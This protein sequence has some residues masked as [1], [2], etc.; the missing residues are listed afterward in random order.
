MIGKTIDRAA[1]TALGAAG[2][3]LFF[4]N[5][6]LGIP[7][8]AALALVCMAL[9]RQV[10]RGLPAK[11]GVTK[12]RAEAALTAIALMG[13][14]EAGQTLRTLTGHEAV[15]PVLRH[16]EGVYTVDMLYDLWRQCGDGVRVAVTC[17][18]EGK[19]RVFAD[20][21]GIDLIDRDALVRLIQRTGLFVP[22]DVPGRPLRSR[23][24]PVWERPIRPRM[25]MAIFGLMTAYLTTG[26]VMCLICA[27]GLTGFMG[28][29]LI[30]R[31]T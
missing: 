18:A 27:L 16:P 21:R 12:A 29:K 10:I 8:S 2:L 5:A 4:L 17:S 30:E 1:L 28:A 20:Q 11:H 15:I 9:L 25:P 31:R 19:A 7:G 14:E 3:Y 22:P 24:R 26:N 6:G 13:E 23:L